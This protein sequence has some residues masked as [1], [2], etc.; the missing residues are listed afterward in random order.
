MKKEI[1]AR[2]QACPR[3]VIMTKKA[4]D[5]LENKSVTTIVDN[6]VSKDNVLK[7]AKSYGYS[8]EIDKSSEGDYYIHISKG[9]EEQGKANLE[10]QRDQSDTADQEKILEESNICIPDTFKDVTIA[11][12]SN[13]MGTGSDELGNIL[14]KSFI[15][16]IKETTPWPA[17]VVLYNSGVYL[18]CEGSEVLEDLQAMAHEGVEIISCGACLDYYHLTDKL[19]AGEIGNMYSIYEKMRNANNTINI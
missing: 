9:E 2:G 3:P 6:E 5:D 4:L 8:F 7:L 12:S 13:K 1:D 18:T 14:M 11:I 15:Y 10:D 16:T 17:T 19:K